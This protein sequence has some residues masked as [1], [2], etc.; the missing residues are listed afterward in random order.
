MNSYYT[1]LGSDR[2]ISN[3]GDSRNRQ[4][5]DSDAAAPA[6]SA[7]TLSHYVS[8]S[9][10]GA[11]AAGITPA[12]SGSSYSPAAT[13]TPG[14]T[15]VPN[16]N[17]ESPVSTIPTETTTADQLNFTTSIIPTNQITFT[18]EIIPVSTPIPPAMTLFGSGLAA[19][20]MLRRRAQAFL[21]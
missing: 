15:T 18:T 13:I 21:S 14:G 17:N 1:V 8:D 4:S 3:T 7:I 20:A 19:L 9:L 2:P 10:V 11:V 6:V 16:G 12:T 5:L